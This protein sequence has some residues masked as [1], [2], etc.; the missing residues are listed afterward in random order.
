MDTDAAA[1]AEFYSSAS[2]DCLRVVLAAVRDRQA[3]EDLV[4]EA[5]TRAWAS[6]RKV[7]RHPAP[8]AWV[9]RT[10]LNTHR[11]WWRRHR[12]EA[13]LQQKLNADGV[14]AEV[15]SDTHYPAACVDRQAMTQDM[16]SVITLGPQ[17]P[18]EYAFVIHPAAIPSGSKLLLDVTHPTVTSG[19]ITATTGGVGDR[20]WGLG[21][22]SKDVSVSAG[23]GLVY[24]SGNC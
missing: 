15:I 11:S 19:G 24:D 10:A 1:F 4:A 5:F 3:A 22:H 18:D 14:P 20:L 2:D 16:A 17:V 13:G 21:A 9:V 8:R 7:S 6:W 23:M 12:R